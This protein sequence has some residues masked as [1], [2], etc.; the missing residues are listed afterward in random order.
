MIE[1]LDPDNPFSPEGIERIADW[2]VPRIRQSAMFN[3][4]L[5]AR[6][7]DLLAVALQGML[8]EYLSEI[9]YEANV[10]QD[11]NLVIISTDDDE[12]DPEMVNVSVPLTRALFQRLYG[13]GGGRMF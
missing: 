7:A 2:M 11:K 12:D 3:M 13:S 10:R 8:T 1:N 4:A 9:G 6:D 5:A